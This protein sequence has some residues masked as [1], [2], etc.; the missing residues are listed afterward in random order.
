MKG[1]KSWP[2][3][4]EVSNGIRRFDQGHNVHH[5]LSSLGH[6]GE[7]RCIRRLLRVLTVVA[8]RQKR[9]TPTNLAV[10]KVLTENHETY[11]NYTKRTRIEPRYLSI[12]GDTSM[13][14]G[15]QSAKNNFVVHPAG[16]PG[17]LGQSRLGYQ[18]GVHSAPIPESVTER[19][20]ATP[21]LIKTDPEQSA[22]YS[23]ECF[24]R[25]PHRGFRWES[26]L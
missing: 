5:H 16:N 14:K 22:S 23:G 9:A 25:T 12:V 2:K 20:R 6:A 8:I 7:I 24:R 10:Q 3:V 11:C 4:H 1:L 17:M 13:V 18:L 21:S 26:L 15:D 19:Y